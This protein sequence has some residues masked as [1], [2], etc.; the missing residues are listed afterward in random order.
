M[1]TYFKAPPEVSI[2]T[3]DREK[4][5]YFWNNII[6]KS[7]RL[8]MGLKYFGDRNGFPVTGR[9]I[10]SVWKKEISMF[11]VDISVG[12]Y[13]KQIHKSNS[14]LVK[15][16]SD[17]LKIISINVE[18]GSI[19]AESKSGNKCHF[20]FGEYRIFMRLKDVHNVEI[21]EKMFSFIENCKIFIDSSILEFNNENNTN[22]SIDSLFKMLK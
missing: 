12:D 19:V 18:D 13:I 14:V 22:I 21:A 17:I 16:K 11:V 15:Y 6:S 9:E 8:E 3:T 2:F 10:E 4:A 5:M 20:R 1:V 7:T